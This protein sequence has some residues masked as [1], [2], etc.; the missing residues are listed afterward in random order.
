M[1]EW[2]DVMNENGQA[3]DEGTAEISLPYLQVF[4]FTIIQS[5]LP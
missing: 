3:A 5:M 2:V 4:V 1:Y